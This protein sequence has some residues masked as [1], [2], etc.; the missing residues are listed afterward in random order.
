MK[1]M[2]FVSG[3][4]GSSGKLGIAF[5]MNCFAPSSGSAGMLGNALEIASMAPGGSSFEMKALPSRN[6]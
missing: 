6:N 4:T 2:A 1:D 5:W 3:S